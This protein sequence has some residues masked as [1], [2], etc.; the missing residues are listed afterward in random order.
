MADNGKST[1]D[2]TSKLNGS[3]KQR[4]PFKK[5]RANVELTRSEVKRI[6]AE[7]KELRK[8]LRKAGI[9]SKREFELTASG[10]GLYF[11]KKSGLAA[12]LLLW[13]GKALWALAG[14]A[15]A[16]L[17]LMYTYSQVVEKQ[18]HFTINLSD[19]LM[20]SGFRLSETADF[21]NSSFT[22]Y[23]EPRAN[24]PAV[25]ISKIPEDVMLGDGQ[26]DDQTFFAYSY[27]LRYEGDM[28]GVY[29]YEIKINSEGL[30]TSSA[31]WVMVFAQG[32]M[33]F[34]AKLGADG[35]PEAVPA[36]NDNTRGF[37]KA[38][39][40]EYAENPSE[41]YQIVAQRGDRVYYRVVPYPFVDDSTVMR[42]TNVPISDMEVHKFTV[43]LWLEGEDPECTN[44]LIGGHLG[45]EMNFSLQTEE[46]QE[47]EGVAE[48]WS[49]FTDNLKNMLPV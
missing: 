2:N 7:R 17:F 48:V 6:K 31:C 28:S 27:Y 45:L 19:E 15:L 44:D 11:D 38:Y 14:A 33:N 3:D 24:V 29:D 37:P 1:Q 40:T 4:T 43:V 46:G 36:M 20:R 5:T 8:R 42:K 10:M 34:Y 22:L 30:N 26:Y 18:G 23:S 25:S 9:K 39:F 41:Q 47:D 12:L 35:Q 49:Q 32:K 16:A 21:A 13:G